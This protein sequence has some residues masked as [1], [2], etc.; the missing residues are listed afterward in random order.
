[1]MKRHSKVYLVLICF[2]SGVIG[3]TT[4][5]IVS[6]SKTHAALILGW[7]MESVMIT[8][9]PMIIITIMVTAASPTMMKIGP[10]TAMTA[11]AGQI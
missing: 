4:A 5:L 2:F 6:V 10:F 9:T 3:I 1:M 7:V 8:A 11:L